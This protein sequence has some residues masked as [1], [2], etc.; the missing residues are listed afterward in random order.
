MLRIN[1]E[2]TIV[3]GKL[4]WFQ[5]REWLSLRGISMRT[6]L[7]VGWKSNFLFLFTFEEFNDFSYFSF[8][9]IS[10]EYIFIKSFV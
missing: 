2:K 4:F 10:F 1:L 5:M 3:Q 8:V 6:D 9:S 7:S